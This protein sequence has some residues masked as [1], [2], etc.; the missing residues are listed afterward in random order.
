MTAD[1][2]RKVMQDL[3]AVSKARNT[4]RLS[5]ILTRVKELAR[6]GGVSGEAAD[7]MLDLTPRELEALVFGIQGRSPERYF[8]DAAREFIERTAGGM[9]PARKVRAEIVDRLIG[10]RLITRAY[11]TRRLKEARNE[12]GSKTA[13]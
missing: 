13:K 11:A 1:E 3:W 4:R 7:A 12:L 6:S 5:P 9:E 10:E 8:E 2:L